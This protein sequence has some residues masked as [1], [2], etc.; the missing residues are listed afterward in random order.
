MGDHHVRI[1]ENLGLRYLGLLDHFL[2][3]GKK[4]KKNRLVKLTSLFGE[5]R[6][7]YPE[8]LDALKG[9]TLLGKFQVLTD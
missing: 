7:F 1:Y 5:W 8:R 4:N 6:F 2:Q 3:S 9:V